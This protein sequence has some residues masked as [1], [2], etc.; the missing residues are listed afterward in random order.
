MSTQRP[1]HSRRVILMLAAACVLAGLIGDS[2]IRG[3]RQDDL[4][5]Q[6]FTALQHGNT[7]ELSPLLKLG[8]DPNYVPRSQGD[9]ISLSALLTNLRQG[10][11]D[12]HVR[13]GLP[14]LG[15]ALNGFSNEGPRALVRAKQFQM[16]H[17]Q[18]KMMHVVLPPLTCTDPIGK[19]RV[20]L[21]HHADAN[22]NYGG[23]NP[24]SHAVAQNRA[25]AVQLLLQH[26][27]DPDAQTVT[28]DTAR[29]AAT[30]NKYASILALMSAKQSRGNR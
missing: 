25:D 17:E 4:N 23:A 8:A 5:E 28:G 27:A 24:L 16:M 21:E 12:F 13:H 22:L 30:R 7:S 29:S 19:M 6:L 11:L 18:F 14:M 1:K 3:M 15:Y 26:G 20:L 10:R 2:A 9:G